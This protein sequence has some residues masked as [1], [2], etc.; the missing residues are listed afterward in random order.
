LDVKP[1]PPDEVVRRVINALN[2]R[3][4]ETVADAAHEDSL[5][6]FRLWELFIVS[7]MTDDS[8]ADAG[9]DD[10]GPERRPLSEWRPGAVYSRALYTAPG[11]DSPI[12]NR[13]VLGVVPEARVGGNLAH[14]VFRQHD[15]PAGG[16]SIVVTSV[17]ETPTGWRFDATDNGLL[18][19][20][21]HPELPTR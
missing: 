16:E 20:A 15:D 6:Q 1:E 9:R 12:L 14:V 11:A 4:W 10:C 2:A 21:I 19:P 18:L 13:R 17:R 8:T 7:A 5:V 3:Q